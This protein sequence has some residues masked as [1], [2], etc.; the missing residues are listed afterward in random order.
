MVRFRKILFPIAFSEAAVAMASSVREMAQR[1]NA[2]VTVLNACNLAPEYISG[3]ALDAPCDL[4]ERTI[5]FSP[6]LQEVRNQQERRLKEFVRTHFS[7][8]GHTERIEIGDPA[9]VIEWV[10][11]CEKT[12]LIMMPPE[13]WG[14]FAVC[15]W[16]R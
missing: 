1:F 13:D 16:T 9:A 2:S 11:K 10:A 6:A 3:P 14:G 12:D 15:S 8:I 7:G 5:F 4:K